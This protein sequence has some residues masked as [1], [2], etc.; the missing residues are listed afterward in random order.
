MR[1]ESQL[2]PNRNSPATTCVNNLKQIA[3][4]F[5]IWAGSHDGRF[6]PNFLSMS[7][8]LHVA[9]VLCCPLD[10]ANYELADARRQAGGAGWS[11]WPENGGSYEMLGANLDSNSP[12]IAEIIIARCRF[13]GSYVRGD[14]SVMQVESQKEIQ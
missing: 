13:H 10:E 5:R 2:P 3:L 8:E 11:G 9:M 7:N 6:P 12:G 1:P 14:G 4:S